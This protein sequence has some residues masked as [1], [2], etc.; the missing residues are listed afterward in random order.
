[1]QLG[2]I[3]ALA[4][5]CGTA[6]A[7]I[8]QDALQSKVA[9]VRYPPL[10]KQA[11][12]QGDVHLHLDSGVATVV[13]GHPVL[14][15]TSVESAKTFASITGQTPLDLVYHFVIVDTATSVPSTAT[16]KR[17]NALERVV[18]RAFGR[19]TKK[20]VTTYECQSA[21]PPNEVKVS[22]ATVEVWIYGRMPCLQ[23][24][25]S[26]LMARR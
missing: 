19:P 18:L 5:A 17:G 14:L 24:Q 25:S 26:T 9:A 11:R 16:V 13:S 7:Q 12:I 4:L 21:A 10:A 2:R 3:L 20:T 22:G 23:T 8:P 1:M 6:L 15:Q